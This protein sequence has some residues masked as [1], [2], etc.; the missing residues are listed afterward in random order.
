MNVCFFLTKTAGKHV[1]M[2]T[3]LSQHRVPEPNTL[4]LALHG[5]LTYIESL[6]FVFE[7]AL[8]KQFV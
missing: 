5:V 4:F 8:V 7:F 3:K 2:N 1:A 6:R